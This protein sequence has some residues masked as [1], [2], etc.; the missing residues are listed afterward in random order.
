MKHKELMSSIDREAVVA[1][2]ERAERACS[3]EIRV[4]IEPS[5]HGKDPQY[6]AER[7]FE[8]LGMTKTELR[9]GVLIYLVSKQQQFAVIGDRG[10]HEKVGPEFWQLVASHMVEHFR[11]GEFTEGVVQAVEEVGE[12]LSRFFPHQGARDENELSNEISIGNEAPPKP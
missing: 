3:G 12:Q 1:A 5:S 6:L 7:T 8:R 11:K 9:N 4:H 2:I 10:I